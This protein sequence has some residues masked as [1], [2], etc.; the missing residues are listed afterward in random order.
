MNRLSYCFLF[1]IGVLAADVQAETLSI[2]A[3][4]FTQL[5]VYNS[6]GQP[7]YNPADGTFSGDNCNQLQY[8][9]SLDAAI[10]LNE[11]DRLES[12]SCA[13]IDG[14][15]IESDVANFT[16]YWEYKGIILYSGATG[17]EASSSQIG[18]WNINGTGLGSNAVNGNYLSE[19]NTFFPFDQ[20][21]FSWAG[22]PA[23]PV[24][25]TASSNLWI[26]FMVEPHSQTGSCEPELQFL[27]C[28]VTYTAAP[29]VDL[30]A[31]ANCDENASC[32]PEDGACSCNTGF[33]GDGS[34]CS[35]LDECVDNSTNDC[36]ETVEVCVNEPDGGGYLCLCANGYETDDNN[37]CVAAETQ[38]PSSCP[39]GQLLTD[40]I[41][42]S[43]SDYRSYQGGELVPTGVLSE[44]G[45]M[46][47]TSVGSNSSSNTSSVNYF[48]LPE[49]VWVTDQDC[50]FYDHDVDIDHFLWMKLWVYYGGQKGTL[51]NS[52]NTCPSVGDCYQSD[53]GVFDED[54]LNMEPNPNRQYV[55]NLFYSQWINLSAENTVS[56]NVGFFGCHVVLDAEICQEIDD[57]ADNPC[58]N[59]G[60]CI[61]GVNAYT[62]NVPPC[63]KVT[64]AKHLSY[65]WWDTD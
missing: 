64:T 55:G 21:N 3:D 60:R 17:D 47:Y 1:L 5:D 2:D 33:T 53:F 26:R 57:C 27:G 25:I 51:I 30:C 13:V 56:P 58:Q 6:I 7:V 32:N 24:E 63:M 19:S 31:N 10:S 20:T 34:T 62:A 12:I 44:E 28:D 4:A 45:N 18:Q 39:E 52:T 54:T 35:D 46:G 14:D 38:A 36:L 16:L 41:F 48:Y 50:I 37:E 8:T 22:M 29:P 42:L 15:N 65:K 9:H 49:G 59:N 40:T 43:P 23:A 61:D 11:G